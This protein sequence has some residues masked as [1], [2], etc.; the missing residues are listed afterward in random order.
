[1]SQN[2]I[3]IKTIFKMQTPFLTPGLY[4][5]HSRTDLPMTALRPYLI[6]NYT[7]LKAR[8]HILSL[9]V[10]LTV[11]GTSKEK[12]LSSDNLPEYPAGEFISLIKCSSSHCTSA[13][14][15][16]QRALQP[17]HLCLISLPTC[18]VLEDRS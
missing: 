10:S 1:M 18:L 3:F 16:S 6:F 15:L 4:K 2:I 5:S 17:T 12:T 11:P 14:S 13:Q 9:C 7:T 8:D